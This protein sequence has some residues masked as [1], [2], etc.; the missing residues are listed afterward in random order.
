VIVSSKQ[1]ELTA[2]KSRPIEVAIEEMPSYPVLFR[3]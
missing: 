3:D 1:Q 2:E